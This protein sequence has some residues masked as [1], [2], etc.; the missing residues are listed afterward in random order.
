M[1]S[2]TRRVYGSGALKFSAGGGRGGEVVHEVGDEIRVLDQEDQVHD[3]E[4]DADDA[5]N[6]AGGGHPVALL[7]PIR[8][9]NGLPA[10]KAKAKCGRAKN[11]AEKACAGNRKDSAHH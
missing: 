6:D 11:D 4:N 9:G 2:E 8:A 1:L 10:S 7:P 3:G 5:G